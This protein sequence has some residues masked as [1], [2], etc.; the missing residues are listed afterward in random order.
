MSPIIPPTMEY[1]D[2][3][4]LWTPWVYLLIFLLTSVA[5]IWRLGELENRGL[6]GTVLGT[7]V[8]PYCSG[9][10]NLIFAYVLGVS[11]GEGRL[12]LENC[13][14]NNTTNLTLL[15]GLPALI[16]GLNIFPVKGKAAAKGKGAKGKGAKDKASKSKKA[17]AKAGVAE[18][19]R[20]NRLSLLLN[21][22][23]VIFF[24]GALWAQ[25][26]DGQIDRGDAYVLI[27]LFVFWQIIH[28][29]D[30]LKYNIHRK[31]KMGILIWLDMAIIFASGYAMFTSIDWLVNWALQE[32][33][34][35]LGSE[36][37]GWMSGWLMVLPNAMLAFYYAM[38]N[39]AD[40]A[41]S[42]Q[43]GDGHICIPLCIGLFALFSPIQIPD[44][45][46][47]GVY[48]I[49]GATVVHMVLVMLLGRLPRLA[50]LAFSVAY[51]YFL[52]EG[53]IS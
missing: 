14:V 19:H 39:R 23:A 6:E 18:E 46:L 30:V 7:V 41:Y 13:I 2:S 33:E 50:G 28:V 49:L 48:L 17:P 36:G 11:G 16:W 9:L 31:Q 42:S 34:G 20:L 43:I 51:G 40:I 26:Q 15:I 32:G 27:G 44:F 3:L 8:M 22:M 45:F 4:G 21:L 29:F 37:I 10:S 12:V 5:M 24:T 25:S 1:L 53:L 35:L 47:I 38:K 52:Y